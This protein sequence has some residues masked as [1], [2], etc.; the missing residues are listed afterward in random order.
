[1]FCAFCDDAYCSITSKAVLLLCATSFAAATSSSLS[2]LEYR[3][4]PLGS[5]LLQI[6]LWGVV[7]CQMKKKM[8][9]FKCSFH[10]IS[11]CLCRL[12][13]WKRREKR[14]FSLQFWR[15]SFWVSSLLVFALFAPKAKKDREKTCEEVLWG[16]T[17]LLLFLL[18]WGKKLD[19]ES[20]RQQGAQC[21]RCKKVEAWGLH[22]QPEGVPRASLHTHT[23]RMGS[24][25]QY[26]LLLQHFYSFAPTFASPRQTLASF[27]WEGSLRRNDDTL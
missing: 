23:L 24:F 12:G 20:E 26:P 19:T 18:F 7:K 5:F 25:P 2:S 4:F 13:F 10:F 15:A 1:M 8:K 9:I 14:G 6:Y 16:L 21:D 11:S 17:F 22:L 3:L 27:V